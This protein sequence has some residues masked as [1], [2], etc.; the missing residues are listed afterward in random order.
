MCAVC[1]RCVGGV[2]DAMC[3]PF[4]RQEEEEHVRTVYDEA[5]EQERREAVRKEKEEVTRK[6]RYRQ[7]CTQLPSFS[8][9]GAYPAH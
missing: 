1:G 4:Q 6:K 7:T 3:V 5:M 9:S 8:M 2:C